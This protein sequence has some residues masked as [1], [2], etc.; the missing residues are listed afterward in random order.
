MA[1]TNP[2]PVVVIACGRP[3][4]LRRALASIESHDDESGR[5]II[6]SQDGVNNEVAAVAK[7]LRSP[8]LHLVDRGRD[9]RRFPRRSDEPRAHHENRSRYSH[10]AAHFKWT[11]SEI[12]GRLDMDQVIVLEDDIEIAPDFFS[13]FRACASLLERDASILTASAWNDNGRPPLISDPARLYRTDV[14]PGPGWLMTQKLWREFAPIWPDA[15]WD[16]WLRQAAQRKGRSTIRPEVSRTYTFGETGVSAGQFFNDY[17][18]PML[19]NDT[20]VDF[21]A[22]DLGY[23][24]KDRFDAWLRNAVAAVEPVDLDVAFADEGGKDQKI[25]YHGKAGFA[26]IAARFGLMPDFPVDAP[27]SAYD[28]VVWF[29]HKGRRLFVVPI[30]YI[31][32]QSKSSGE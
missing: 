10:I 21:E 15:Y 2:I 23:L 20:P 4:Y 17:L 28:G 16:D 9:Q 8:S 1:R 3:A 32:A 18:E 19:L 27:R 26:E 30:N 25:I 14:F 22:M 7:E 12:F 31:L 11:F 13:Y 6:L 29:R 24:A 5:L